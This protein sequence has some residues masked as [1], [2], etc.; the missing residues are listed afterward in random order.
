MTFATTKPKHTELIQYYATD[1]DFIVS[2][3]DA[4]GL[5]IDAHR[6][7]ISVKPMVVDRR[8]VS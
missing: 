5:V 2:R 7:K 4:Q 3:A 8:P 1:W 6:G